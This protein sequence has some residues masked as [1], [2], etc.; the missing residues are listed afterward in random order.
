VSRDDYYRCLGIVA[1]TMTKSDEY[2]QY[3]IACLKVFIEPAK[4][5]QRAA[6]YHSTVVNG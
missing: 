2:V 4:L 3:P 5:L 1:E 6:L